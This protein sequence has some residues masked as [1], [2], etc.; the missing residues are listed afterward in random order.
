M[1]DIKKSRQRVQHDGIANIENLEQASQ[2]GFKWEYV[3]F[4]P[5]P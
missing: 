5:S 4:A 1:K 3:T 2:A